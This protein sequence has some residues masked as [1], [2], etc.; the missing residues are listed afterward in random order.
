LGAPL[1]RKR[2]ERNDSAIAG[3]EIWR[4]V[5]GGCA[6]HGENGADPRAGSPR[7]CLRCG[8]LRDER[9]DQPLDRSGAASGSWRQRAKHSRSTKSRI[10]LQKRTLECGSPAAA[11]PNNSHDSIFG[12]PQQKVCESSTRRC[13]RVLSAKIARGKRS[14]KRCRKFSRKAAARS[15]LPYSARLTMGSERFAGSPLRAEDL[16]VSKLSIAENNSL[17]R[18]GLET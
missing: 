14:K 3:D 2:A 11:F 13:C 10:I 15:R 7:G 9:S 1:I 17:V 5:R 8:R 16:F 4:D 6:L 18:M 12:E